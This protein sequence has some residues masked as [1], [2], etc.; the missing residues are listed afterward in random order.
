MLSRPRLTL[1][2]AALSFSSHYTGSTSSRTFAIQNSGNASVTVTG[3]VSS[4]P[5]FVLASQALPITLASG[6]SR[7]LNAQFT[8][9]TAASFSGLISLTTNPALANVPALVVSGVGIDPPVIGV[10]PSS[11]ALTLDKGRTADRDVT[12]SNTGGSNLSWQVAVNAVSSG[13][14]S[15][16]QI[17]Q[18][19]NDHHES[20]TSLIPDFLLFHRRRN[21]QFHFRWWTG[22]V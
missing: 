19:L 10:T 7:T 22:H 21:G 18:R 17:L 14:G 9:D 4:Q 20:I 11:L 1:T 16:S 6:E 2:P 15:L 5:Q 13:S 8:P 3:T 12:I